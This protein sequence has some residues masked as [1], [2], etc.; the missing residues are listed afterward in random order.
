M[1]APKTVMPKCKTVMIVTGESSGELY[2]ALLAGEIKGLWPDARVLGAGGER[3][4]RAGVELFA[5]IAGAFGLTE[6]L[7][8]YREVRDTFKKTVDTLG[9]ASPDVVVLI[10]YP[11]F[12]FRV[13][14]MA[15]KAGI[16]VLYYVSP[17]VWAWR[18]GRVKTMARIADR[19]A[20]VLPF[21][22]DIYRAEPIQC[23]FV[24]HPVMDEIRSLPSDRRAL[25]ETLGLDPERPALAFLPGSRTSELRRLLPL[26]LETVRRVRKEFP[27]HELVM[28][29][30]PN[31]DA[32]RYGPFMEEFVKEGVRVVKEK[33]L[34]A[35]SASEAA[36]VASGTATLQAAFL[37]RP[38]VV[39]YKVS[40]VTYFLARMI[41]AVK[42]ITLV[43][44]LL[45]RPVVPE[46]VQGRAT[47]ESIMDELRSVLTD[48]KRR[49][50]MLAGLREVKG[51]FSGRR[52]SRRVAEIVGEMAGWGVTDPR[53]TGPSPSG[54]TD[55]SGVTGGRRPIHSME[56]T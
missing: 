39:V 50:G 42:Y 19:M 53:A 28:P 9:S 43:N 6:A 23:E 45:G 13:A 26:M 11:D 4:A 55:P 8:S 24:G 38:M 41:L 36:V 35:L 44:L 21:E 16:P 14:R 17:Q 46:L 12:N 25:K 5:G 54:V 32:G 10:D 52:P 15:R 33:A 30:A 34:H 47:P 37:E 48:D 49:E 27:R 22:E 18:K 31:L 3:M 56:Q 1:P 20:V 40:P 51:L 29:L 7:A 2:G